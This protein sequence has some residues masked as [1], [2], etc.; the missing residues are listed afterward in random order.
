MPVPS[1]NFTIIADSAVDPDSPLDTTLITALR[2]N[3]IHIEEWLGLSYAAAQ[4]HDH[5]GVNSKSVVLANA[6]VTETKIAA[7]AVTQA[8]LKTTTGAGSLS[9]TAATT[10]TYGLSGGNFSWWTAGA[11]GS[12][13]LFGNS[14]VAAGSIGLANTNGTDTF[15]FYV[16]ERY[17]QAS[18]PYRYGPLFVTL[19]VDASGNIIGSQIAPDPVWAYHGPTDITPQYSR[20][21]K[22][23]RLRRML[24][25]QTLK[26]ALLD[27]STRRA[28]V[29][30]SLAP[31]DEEVEITLA[32]KDSDMAVMPHPFGVVPPG[33]TVLLV[34]PGTPLMDKLYEMLVEDHA[35]AVRDLF[36]KDFLR[37]DNAR[38][39]DLPGAPPILKCYDVR[40]KLT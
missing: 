17:V 6:V 5:D 23:Y 4:D 1:K 9:L 33:A 39:I 12:N 2:D 28:F 19:M 13:I 8:K 24:N 3:T 29:E 36:L 14:D 26:Q 20:A 7:A 10:G 34:R 11:S 31:T 21:G 18:P 32:Y 35:R 38:A 27:P 37:V 22:Q 30:G 25:S 16:D 15:V 40:W